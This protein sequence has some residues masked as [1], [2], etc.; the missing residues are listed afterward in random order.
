[1][2]VAIG[3]KNPTK[4]QAVLNVFTK[5]SSLVEFLPV[6]V[7][8]GV[9]EQ[10]IGQDETLRGARNRARKALIDAQADIGIGLEGGVVRTAHGIFTMGWVVI[11][12]ASM[13]E[14]VAGSTWL[15]LPPAVGEAVLSGG[16]LGPEMDRL[17]G[18]SDTKKKNGAVGIL[19]NNLCDRTTA[20]EVAV[21]CALAPLLRPDL[22]D[23]QNVAAS[24]EWSI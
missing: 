18:E 20:W 1:M 16:E 8:S 7:P 17:T 21:A 14:G 13:R 12:D 22:Y 3:S 2:K 11:V 15:M 9:S 6:A 4:V 5:H 19:T 24:K 10:P 23:G